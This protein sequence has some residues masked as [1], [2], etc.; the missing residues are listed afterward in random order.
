MSEASGGAGHDG[1]GRDRTDD[2]P[3][4]AGRARGAPAPGQGAPGS[5]LLS[6]FQRW[7]IR[8]S[9]KS[10]SKEIGGQVRRTLR[11]GR[12]DQGDVWD[13]ATSEALHSDGEAPECQW[14]PICRA[15]RRMRE[16]GPGLGDQ[17][18]GAGDAVASAVQD[19]IR[20]F[21]SMLSRTGGPGP[22]G[23]QASGNQG[24][25]QASGGQASG[26]QAPGDQDPGGQCAP[27]GEPGPED[28]NGPDGRG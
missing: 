5:E 6:S 2:E 11:G 16:S 26:G 27:V 9:A 21:D 15:A 20:A 24:G 23:S 12:T 3:G 13:V 22:G 4:R 10:M 1:H 7:L 18:S 25:G 19:A 14:C 8:S 17:L 28:M